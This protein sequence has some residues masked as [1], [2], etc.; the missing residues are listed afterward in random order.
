MLQFFRDKMKTIMI[1]I[2]V[3]FAASMFYGLGY[4]GLNRGDAGKSGDTKGI[5]KVNG[6]DVDAFRFNQ[7]INRLASESKGSIDPMTALYIQSMGLNQLVDFTLMA[8]DASGKVSVANEEVSNAVAQIMKQN[9]IPDE[10][11]FNQILKQ[12]GFSMSDLRRMI[13]EEI[14]V[15]KMGQKIISEVTVT[16]DDMRE[17]N[18]QHILIA[19]SDDK[20]KKKAE[21]VL[22]LAKSGKDFGQLAKEYSDDPSS[23]NNGGSLGF[24]KK[25]TM[26]PEFDKA[27]FALNPG[28][29]SDL[30]K[31]Q[32]GY[33]IIKMNE[34]RMVKGAN[35]DKILEEKKKSVSN[36]WIYTLRT[37]AKIEILNPAIKAFDK[38]VK[39]DLPGALADY[40]SAIKSNPNNPYYHL[41][42]ADLL[43]QMNNNAGAIEE[44]KAASNTSA[45]DPY[46]HIYV[47]KA[48]TKS[49]DSSKGATKEAYEETARQEF[50]KASILAGENIDVH[51]DLAKMFKQMNMPQ[52]Y[53]Q[54]QEK[55]SQLEMKKKLIDELKKK[56]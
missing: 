23:A 25:G 52:A 39:G 27:V 30:V 17:V 4:Q 31:T 3:L 5:A 44:Y 53:S 18:A 1:V 34:S 11:S 28:Q 10:K 38:R 6:K 49:A 8:Q 33:H 13:K 21:E 56:P 7:I 26:V 29:I 24:F 16:A 54:E 45:P 22:K 48:L 42:L 19:G 43:Q 40:R 35:K 50:S 14:Q 55:I 47:G 32:F 2:A 41:Y 15:Q 51:K 46:L 37:K 36:A 20:A 12:Q 9:N